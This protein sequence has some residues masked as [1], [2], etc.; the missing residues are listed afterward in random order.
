MIANDFYIREVSVYR[1]PVLSLSVDED[2][3][4]ENL[5]LAE[6]EDQEKIDVHILID[7]EGRL[8]NLHAYTGK[9]MKNRPK[10]QLQIPRHYF[11]IFDSS[12]K[13][14]SIIQNSLILKV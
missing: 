11:F 14:T 12:I 9:K 7:P 8:V 5:T 1:D 10:A 4:E 6:P 2:T 13:T 3:G